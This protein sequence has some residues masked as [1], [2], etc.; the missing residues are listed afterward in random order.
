M[1]KKCYW[2]KMQSVSAGLFGLLEF[3]E[4]LKFLYFLPVGLEIDF[5]V[6]MLL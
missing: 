5:G 4:F 1:K 6:S 3:L 2:E